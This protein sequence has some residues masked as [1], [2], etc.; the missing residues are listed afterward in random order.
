MAAPAAGLDA[1]WGDF[2]RRA[3][4]ARADEAA[5]VTARRTARIADAR[6]CARLLVDRAWARGCRLDSRV[7][8][9]LRALEPDTLCSEVMY[10]AHD[11]AKREWSLLK[12]NL[13]AHPAVFTV[14]FKRG[15][16]DRPL[17]VTKE[18]HHAFN[19]NATFRNLFDNEIWRT[20]QASEP[21]VERPPLL[22][23]IRRELVER[24]SAKVQGARS[25]A[26]I[27]AA[28][29]ADREAT[30]VS[31]THMQ[32]NDGG[33]VA[34]QLATLEAEVAAVAARAR[35]ELAD[36]MQPHL[37]RSKRIAYW[38]AAYRDCLTT[39][40]EARGQ[41]KGALLTVVPPLPEVRL[42]EYAIT[43]ITSL[44]QSDADEWKPA[45]DIEAWLTGRRREAGG[46]G[47]EADR[48]A[49]LRARFKR[50]AREVLR[51]AATRITGRFRATQDPLPERNEKVATSLAEDAD[52]LHLETE[53]PVM[54]GFRVV[55]LE[56]LV[57]F[58]RTCI[59]DGQT[60][61][62]ATLQVNNMKWEKTEGFLRGL[63]R[64]VG[65]LD[66][67]STV[68]YG[69]S[70]PDNYLNTVEGA[71]ERLTQ[72]T[73][74]ERASLP[75][76][77]STMPVLSSKWFTDWYVERDIWVPFA[78][79][80]RAHMG[81]FQAATSERERELVQQVRAITDQPRPL[82]RDAITAYFLAIRIECMAQIREC[83]SMAMR[84]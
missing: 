26:E 80:L 77:V 41:L 4:E 31:A 1:A 54:P 13:H 74:A 8:T 33:R 35:K 61:S 47:S 65:K 81:A 58:I 24:A 46:S 60:P 68:V 30:Q 7:H 9:F 82:C 22:E 29:A 12:S 27:E 44:K 79:Q 50:D 69:G 2:L 75:P 14:F 18:D 16:A 59:S 63:K 78:G 73:R 49:Y 45:G 40:Q 19:T 76:L 3:V 67:L 43:E 34:E 70:T 36:S 71:L 20:S 28:E 51:G 15:P 10:S 55:A 38:E 56:D 83:M 25:F 66:L 5:Q 84:R 11:K 64:L 42:V 57:G 6:G 17:R 72:A 39:V 37:E 52:A 23:H 62:Q 48:A 21:R 32:Q 53:I